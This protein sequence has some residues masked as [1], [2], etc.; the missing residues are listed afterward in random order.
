[1]G[2]IETTIHLQVKDDRAR[3]GERLVTAGHSLHSDREGAVSVST[4]I[5]KKKDQR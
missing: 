1:M 2:I 3:A 4:V 5:L